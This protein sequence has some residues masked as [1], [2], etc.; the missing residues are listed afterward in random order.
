MEKF[1]TIQNN[2]TLE[3][4]YRVTPNVIYR[5][6]DGHDLKMHIIHP[7]VNELNE[8]L[9][10]PLI[11][12]IQ[13][14]AWTHPDMYTEI[15]ALSWYASQGYVVATVDHRNCADGYPFP[16]YL[17]DVKCALRF[18]RAHAKEYRIDP[19]R[20]A[21]YGTSSGGN[22]ALLLGMTGDDPRYK[23]EEYAEYSDSVC[24]VAECFGPTDMYDFARF[25][26]GNIIFEGI[27]LT[28]LGGR[29][30]ESAEAA[31]RAHDMS[32]VCIA[33]PGK[34]YP[35]IFILHGSGD[36]L[37][38]YDVHGKALFDKLDSFGYDVSMVCVENGD[39]EGNFWSA[40]VHELVLRFIDE[41]IKG[42]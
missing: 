24:A 36:W 27:I 23:T 33:E 32:P 39:H 2:P 20:V 7:W 35:P 31:Q 12:F 25:L 28:I 9:R 40:H 6:V 37:V 42:I 29:P 4:S 17:E 8:D 10:L 38:N 15:P 14:S 5:S 1:T 34:N 19:D 18:L 16:A 30:R 11:L 13:G 41:K 22:T 3:S 21:A 26:D